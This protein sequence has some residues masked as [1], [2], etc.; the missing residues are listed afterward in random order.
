MKKTL[1]DYGFV[2]DLQE[3][4]LAFLSALPFYQHY[5]KAYSSF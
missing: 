1:D 5:P 4:Q 3:F 2:N